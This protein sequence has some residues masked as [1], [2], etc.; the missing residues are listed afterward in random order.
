[1][2]PRVFLLFCWPFFLFTCPYKSSKTLLPISASNF[3]SIKCEND[4]IS[5]YSSESFSTNQM[6]NEFAYAVS[7]HHEWSQVIQGPL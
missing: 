5:C 3:I 2:H 4:S 6:K 1:M 7:G